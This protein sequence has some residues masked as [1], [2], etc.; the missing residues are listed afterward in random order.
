MQISMLE[1]SWLVW[2]HRRT[3]LRAKKVTRVV[4]W[5]K[6]ANCPERWKYTQTLFVGFRYTLRW[7]GF[8]H[9]IFKPL[10][11]F[12]LGWGRKE[13]LER[14][15]LYM[16]DPAKLPSCWAKEVAAALPAIGLRS[17]AKNLLLHHSSQG[18]LAPFTV[19]DSNKCL[20]RELSVSFKAYS[21]G[22]LKDPL[23]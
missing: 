7:R 1:F 20:G 9:D 11:T 2:L 12:K 3:G 13:K 10:G 18:I 19:T 23:H 14:C 15:Q 22:Q 6:F 21:L 4:D 17:W 8:V 5:K 16:H